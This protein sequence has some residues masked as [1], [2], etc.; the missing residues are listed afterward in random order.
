MTPFDG[1]SSQVITQPSLSAATTPQ[2]VSA[3]GSVPITSAY[4]ISQALYTQ[5]LVA[6]HRSQVNK[7]AA[8]SPSTRACPEI[9]SYYALKLLITV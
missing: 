1:G 7:L 8:A 6:N 9:V 4:D 2:Q 3:I 5:Q